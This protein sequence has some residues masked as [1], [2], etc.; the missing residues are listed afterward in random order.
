[1]IDF[2]FV[3]EDGFVIEYEDLISLIGFNA[4]QHIKERRNESYDNDDLVLSYLNREKYSIT[5]YV[6]SQ[7]GL[8][9]PMETLMKSAYACIPNLAYAFK[10]MQASHRNGLTRLYVHTDK[11]SP[12]IEKYVQQLEI[13]TNYVHGDI[14][15]VLHNLPNCTY[16]TSNPDNIRK[17]AHL[18]V[19]IALTIVDDFQ[20]VAP[21][22]MDKKLLKTLEDR[23]VYVQYT[24]VISAG[25]I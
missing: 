14:I 20:Y 5:E 11:H 2:S 4:V 17:C 18:D 3:G 6:E 8:H 24:G 22:I 15:P 19:P 7:T 25:I 9:I 1:M 12:I 23:N 21:I 13:K 16:T 10:M